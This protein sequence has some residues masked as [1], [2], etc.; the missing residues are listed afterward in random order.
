[1]DLGV[2]FDADSAVFVHVPRIPF[3][4]LSSEQGTTDKVF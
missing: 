3:H 2:V 4:P 1:M